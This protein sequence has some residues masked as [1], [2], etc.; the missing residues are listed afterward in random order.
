MR[1]AMSETS[2]ALEQLRQALER[3]Y[4]ERLKDFRLPPPSFT[5]MQGEILSFDEQ[6]GRLSA[7]FPVLESQLNPYQL[8][9]GGFMAAAVDNT[10]GPLSLLVAPPNVTRRLELT[11]SRPAS[12]ETGFL[13]VNARLVSRSGRQLT[14]HADVLDAQGRRLARAQATHWI[15]EP[16]SA[17]PAAPPAAPAAAPAA[18]SA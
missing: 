12:L 8:L 17:P 1:A 6:A 3:R 5:S 7:R 15:L 9:Q 16:D 10:L 18:D 11:Y 14:F 13:V 4:G 2:A